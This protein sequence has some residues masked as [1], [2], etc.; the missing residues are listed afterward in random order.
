L[1]IRW[2]KIKAKLIDL[3]Y[4]R[5]KTEENIQIFI[6]EKDEEEEEEDDE[7]EYSYYDEED[8]SGS[9]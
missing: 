3:C 1:Q 8:D 6:S 5:P 7:P 9:E 4:E 2:P